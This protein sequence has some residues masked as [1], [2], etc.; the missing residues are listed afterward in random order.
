MSAKPVII[1]IET[2]HSFRQFSDPAKLGVSVVIAYDYA[3]GIYHSYTEDQLS[4]LF[5][6]LEAASHVIGYN[7]DGFDLPVLQA[8]YHGDVFAFSRFD[9][10]EDIRQTTGRRFGLNDISQATLG[11]KKTANGLQALEWYKTGQIDKIIEYC[12]DDVKITKQVFE[13]GAT[14]GN[15]YVGA[16]DQRAKIPTRWE[17]YRDGRGLTETVPSTLP[18]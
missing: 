17:K 1:D 9:M 7:S 2:K 4:D 12:R 14:Y 6:R 3:D 13:Y 16:G 15:V 5:P 8:Y 10:L 11:I 18:F